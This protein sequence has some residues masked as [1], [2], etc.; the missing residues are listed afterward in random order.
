[1]E[2]SNVILKP[3]T[4][5]KSLALNEAKKFV[6]LVNKQANKIEVMQAIRQ[7][8]GEKPLSCRMVKTMSK[9]NSR[10]LKRGSGKKAII[11]FSKESKFDPTKTK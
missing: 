2:L 9:S 10:R 6:F 3:L 7:F 4:T 1:M 11:S 5:E 8:Y